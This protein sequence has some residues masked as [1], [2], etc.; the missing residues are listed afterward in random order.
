LGLA[1][2]ALSEQPFTLPPSF[3]GTWQG[4]PYASVIGPCPFP[5]MI[6]GVSLT[7][8]LRP[9]FLSMHPQSSVTTG[10]GR[11][12]TSEYP[13]RSEGNCCT[14]LVPEALGCSEWQ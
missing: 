13:V 2:L 4:I 8:S 5:A 7:M 11:G 12:L 10:A 14:A 6:W 9:T 3:E 1:A